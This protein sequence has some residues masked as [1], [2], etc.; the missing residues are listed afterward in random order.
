MYSSEIFNSSWWWIWPVL[1]MVM[2]FF[3]MR[4]W[5]G[6]MICGFGHQR[7]QWPHFNSSDSAFDILDKRYAAGDIDKDEY[8]E[9]KRI[10][11]Q[12]S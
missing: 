1:M 3:M 7:K 10:L 12:E 2:C 5:K 11:I 4:K 8:E 6:R 9:K